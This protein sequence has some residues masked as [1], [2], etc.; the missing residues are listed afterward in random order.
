MRTGRQFP[1][2]AMTEEQ[3]CTLENWA[4]RLE[5]RARRPPHRCRGGSYCGVRA[6]ARLLRAGL[7]RT[8][9][10]LYSNLGTPR[11]QTTGKD[12]DPSPASTPDSPPGGIRH[13]R[14]GLGKVDRHVAGGL[15]SVPSRQGPPSNDL[16]H[17]STHR[18]LQTALFFIHRIC[19][20]SF[21]AAPIRLRYPCYWI[22]NDW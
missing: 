11:L 7:S 15:F 12:F 21:P 16:S 2:L 19:Y 18:P 6:R 4:R 8:G 3:R 14:E 20:S 22:C 17:Q 1:I 5:L 9:T 13:D 10:S